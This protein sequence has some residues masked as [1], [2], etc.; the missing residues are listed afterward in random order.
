MFRLRDLKNGFYQI[1]KKGG[2]AFEGTAKS[3]FI[4]AV[5]MGVRK[6]DLTYSV[7]YMANNRLDYADFDRIGRLMAVKKN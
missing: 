2:Q 4:Q 7:D 3:I 5:V 1:H 6:E